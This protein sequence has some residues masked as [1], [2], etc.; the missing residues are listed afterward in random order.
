M[1]S[2]SAGRRCLLIH[3]ASVQPTDALLDGVNTTIQATD[4]D[5]GNG[6]KIELLLP[7]FAKSAYYDPVSTTAEADALLT[8]SIVTPELTAQINEIAND[9]EKLVTGMDCHS[10]RCVACQALLTQGR[11]GPSPPSHPACPSQN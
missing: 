11:A 10:Q 4:T 8:S 3:A 6:L 5:E 7:S 2:R 1:G 9:L